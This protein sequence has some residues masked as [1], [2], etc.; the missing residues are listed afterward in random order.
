MTEQ[1]EKVSD[2]RVI[3]YGEASVQIIVPKSGIN[4]GKETPVLSMKAFHPVNVRK[5]DGTFDEKE[6]IWYDMKL[7]DSNAKLISSFLKDG[8]VLRVSGEVKPRT[9]TGRD[10]QERQS[11]DLILYSLA[12]DI[13]QR[14]L[15]TVVFE[16]PLKKEN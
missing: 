14:G 1:N 16:K 3:C 8:L 10:G 15:K 5:E 7:Y 9:W 11:K 4:A 2:H 13:K 12:I 6:P